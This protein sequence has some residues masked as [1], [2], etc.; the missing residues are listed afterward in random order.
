VD[1]TG[2]E[3]F[4]R[5]S[6]LTDAQLPA[7]LGNCQ[8]DGAQIGMIT[9]ARSTPQVK[10]FIAEQLRTACVGDPAAGRIDGDRF[11]VIAPGTIAEQVHAVVGGTLAPTSCA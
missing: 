9:Y 7:A 5:T 3:E 6:R 10:Q 1:L 8:F 11:V 2:R 4:A